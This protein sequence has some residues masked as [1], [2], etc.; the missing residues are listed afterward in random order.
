M[1]LFGWRLNEGA[2]APIRVWASLY[3]VPAQGFDSGRA[4]AKMKG[5]R[6]EP[7]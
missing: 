3:P 1:P 4:W 2:G 5:Y 7:W 6:A